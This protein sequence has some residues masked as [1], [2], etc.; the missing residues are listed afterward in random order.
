MRQF[1]N[2][3]WRMVFRAGVLTAAFVA[4][5]LVWQAPVPLARGAEPTVVV[6]QATTPEKAAPAEKRPPAAPP[7]DKSKPAPTADTKAAPPAPATPKA[8]SPGGE[9]KSSPSPAEPAGSAPSDD[10][11]VNVTVSPKGLHIDKGGKHVRIDGLGSDK[12]YDSFESF[13]DD[14]PW[15]AGL[16]FMIVAL[17]FATPLILIILII[18]YKMRKARMLN[19]TMIRLAEKGVVPTADTMAVAAGRTSVP[20]ALAMA[21]VYDQVRSLQK[22]TAW[23]DLRKGVVLIALGLGFTFYWMFNAASASWVGL[24][25]LF[26]GIGYCVLWFFEDRA[27]RGTRDPGTPPAAGT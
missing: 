17:I 3:L 11:D 18:W 16:V 14:A 23:S 19:E 25:L 2:P 8:A 24:I 21:P 5:M 13:V 20:G 10:D 15:L 1:A 26:L 9:T 7:S 22:Q 4:A 6:A 12:E 27:P